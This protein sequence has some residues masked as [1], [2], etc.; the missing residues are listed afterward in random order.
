MS[1]S[2]QRREF[3]A[4]DFSPA[5]SQHGLALRLTL[6]ASIFIGI[7]IVVLIYS[8]ISGEDN[9][10]VQTTQF[11]TQGQFSAPLN[12]AFLTDLHVRN[13]TAQLEK[14]NSIIESVRELEPDL[15]L[16]GGDFT[17]E[18]T[19]TTRLFRAELITALGAL[20][21]IAPT[22]AILGNHEWWTANDWGAAITGVGIQLIENKQRSLNFEQGRICLRG[23]GDAY[24]GHYL[25]QPFTQTCIGIPITLTHDPLVIESDDQSGLYLAGHTHCGQVRLPLIGAPWAPTRASEEYQC[26]VGATDQKVWLVSAG[27]GTSIIPFRFG[28]DA[29]I[30]H[31]IL[32]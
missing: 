29:T 28:T 9:F 15:I 11:D 20:P 3:R 1:S 12:I 19:A 27:L 23:L 4:S 8:A 6:Y 5:P 25:P 2:P 24:T 30:E 16:L 7:V 18:D 21:Q 32:K 31:V 10:E 26:G 14:L 22:Y 13:S 17:G